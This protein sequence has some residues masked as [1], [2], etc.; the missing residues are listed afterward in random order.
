MF[1]KLNFKIGLTFLVVLV[2][3]VVAI[4]YIRSKSDDEV[5]S[6]RQNSGGTLVESDD[7][8]VERAGSWTTQETKSASS[9]SYLYSSGSPADVLILTFV[10]SRVEVIYTTGTNLGTLAVDIDHTVLR[11]VITADQAT[12]YQERTV[13][14]YLDDG[15]HT[16]RV[17]AQEGGVIGIDGFWVSRDTKQVMIVNENKLADGLLEAV[18][19][20]ERVCVAVVLQDLEPISSRGTNQLRNLGLIA[21]V[22]NQVLDSLQTGD[23]EIIYKYE[24]IP[25]LAGYAD[26][27]ALLEL[28]ANPLVIS[29]GV[30][31]HPIQPTLGQSVPAIQAD[32][33]QSYYG[34]TGKGMVVAVID[35]G[36]DIDHP[37]LSDDIIRQL[38][39]RVVG[40]CPT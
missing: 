39:Y 28:Q 21:Q 33:V 7:V 31:C 26:L 9:G 36:V 38:W 40:K 37:D 1:K 12:Q 32:L 11:T 5:K 6:A 16:L 25:G 20:N 17:Y 23:F 30:A 13:V 18:Q 4:G 22:Q 14:D 24:S 3:L 8:V 2:L 27:N 35:T 10:G 29:V 34:I 15:L 19:A